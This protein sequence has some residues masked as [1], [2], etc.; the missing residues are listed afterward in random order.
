MRPI[1]LKIKGI[2]SYVTEQE[3]C[4][5]KLSETNLFGVFGE[6]GSGKTTILDAIVIALYG[7]SDRE[8]IPNMINVNSNSA[9]IKFEFEMVTPSE[10]KRYIV[11]RDYKVRKSGV[12]SEAI[13]IDAKTNAVLAEMTDKVN[14]AVLKIIGVGK[15]E[16]LKCIALP[17]GEFANFLLDTPAN[18]KKT[19]AKLFNLENFGSNLQEKLKARRDVVTLQKLSL[20]EKIS[21]YGDVSNEK[22]MLL[23]EDCEQ[24]RTALDNLRKEI[25]KNKMEYEVLC[26]DYDL[27]C[28]LIESMSALSLKKSEIDEINYLKRQV[29]YTKK[30][31]DF[32]L[33]Y[34]K[35]QT[36]ATESQTLTEQ[37][38]DYKKDLLAKNKNLE[39]NTEKI[40]KLKEVKK[41]N[42]LSL[43]NLQS[44]IKDYNGY[45]IKIESAEAKKRELLQEIDTL[46]SAI[47]ALKANLSDY[48]QQVQ[49]NATEYKKL[50]RSI[51]DNM[52]VLD[53]LR[54]VKALQT[55]ESFLDYINYL[56]GIISPDSLQEVYQY[57]IFEEVNNL[58]ASMNDFD[59]RTRKDIA[60]LQQDY[61]T[62]L[63]YNSSLED[64]QTKLENKNTDLNL[65]CDKIQT[66]IDNSKKLILVSETQII[67]KES[68]IQSYQNSIKNLDI[69]IVNYKIL[70]K[71]L[72]GIDKYK[73][74]EQSN[75]QLASELEAL[76]EEVATQTEERNNLLVNIELNTFALAS[77]KEQL[78]EVK[79]AIKKLGISAEG[80]DNIE[81]VNLYLSDD[82]LKRAEQRIE[83]YEKDLTLLT[84]KVQE[85][86]TACKNTGVTKEVVKNALN[87][88][89]LCEVKERETSVELALNIQLIEQLKTNAKK[90]E[91]LEK[92]LKEVNSKLNTISALA[93]LL[94]NGALLDYV[95]EEYMYLITEFS[96]KYVYDISKG[97]YLLKYDGEFYV[98]DNFNGGISRGV[99][100]LSGGERFIISLSLALGISQSIATNNNKNFN[101]F[102]IDEGFGSLSDGYVENV[103]QAFDTLIKL[104]F[105]VGFISHVEK[106]QNYINNRIIVTKKNNDE[107]SIIKQYY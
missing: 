3:V 107:G 103:L 48:K 68:L 78:A 6:T 76:A 5:D 79:K 63:R 89:N 65:L 32:I 11:N 10:T 81:D 27:N 58:I 25:V 91:E 72:K 40:A 86:K 60:Q 100:T 69:E 34:N 90:V 51:F 47:D 85:Y 7:T 53:K 31:G 43:K 80:N 35:Q 30:Y 37:L 8:S 22:L 20:Q 46:F 45:N 70:I 102:F 55:T 66:N 99:K 17:Q 75:E 96:N 26:N 41:N 57:D 23:E 104:N 50:E 82:E 98:L 93:G 71:S 49:Q 28:K 36:L 21:I 29:D 106:M 59:L 54:E 1:N 2:N 14:D 52:D 19:I 12:K 61:N 84:N 18:R 42:D 97:K 24:K 94:G 4:F 62:L 74:L 95:S 88:L 39:S 16:F 13:L 101:F 105:T 77:Y 87:E 64:L 56:K 92:E 15:K 73:L 83:Q 33:Y 44:A 67:E 38:K 9:Y